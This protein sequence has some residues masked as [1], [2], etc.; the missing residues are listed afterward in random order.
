MFLKGKAL[1]NCDD[2]E[3][4][5]N[6]ASFLS[7]QTVDTVWN[8]YQKMWSLPYVGHP[9]HT[10]ADQGPQFKSRRWEGLFHLAKIDL[11]LSGVEG[12]NALGEVERYHSCLRLIFKKV[13]AD[14][15][16]LDDNY[17]LQLALKAVNDT[18]GPNGLVPTLLVLSILPRA[19]AVRLTCGSKGN[20]WKL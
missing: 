9:E 14:F 18:A 3:T 19:L 1:L 2:R 15:P 10:H 11:T 5:F 16:H 20:A 12:H 6:A 7:D 4:K 8:A 17:A 13:Q